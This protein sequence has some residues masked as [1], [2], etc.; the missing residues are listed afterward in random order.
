MK[1]EIMFYSG[2]VIAVI[3]LI[4]AI[5]SFIKLNVAEALCDLVGINL[6]TKK[7]SKANERNKEKRMY[8]SVSRRIKVDN[9]VRKESS[10]KIDSTKVMKVNSNTQSKGNLYNP[11]NAIDNESTTLL[12]NNENTTLLDEENT[13][14]LDDDNT[15]LLDDE[16]TTLLDEDNTT[17]LD[18]E[19]TT[20]IDG[21]ETT[22]I[23]DELEET[24][25]IEDDNGFSDEFI[26][27]IDIVLVNSDA[28]I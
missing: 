4:L 17:L 5:I 16:N 28:I 7:N 9:S 21:E 3:T 10:T 24:M 1:Y 12:D 13:I 19:I 8:S 26:K 25:L 23:S 2:L 11:L 15:T 6:K 14:M 20:L 27:E 22:I 18:E